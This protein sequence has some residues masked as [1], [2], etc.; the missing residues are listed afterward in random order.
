MGGAGAGAVGTG[1]GVG[2]VGTGAGVVGTGAGAGVVG[3]YRCR[4][5]GTGAGVGVVGPVL[6]PG[7]WKSRCWGGG[8]R[9]RCRVV[10]TGAGDGV[11]GSGVGV[12]VVGTGG[13]GVAHFSQ[14]VVPKRFTWLHDAHFQRGYVWPRVCMKDCRNESE[15]LLFDVQPSGATLNFGIHTSEMY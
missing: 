7:G 8:D 4:V 1:A 9:Y 15:K 3:W 11:V 6:V 5:V 10:G 2:V 14:I 12:G 13:D